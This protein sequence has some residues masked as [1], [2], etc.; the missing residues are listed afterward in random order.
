MDMMETQRFFPNVLIVD[1]KEKD[2]DASMVGGPSIMPPDREIKFVVNMDD[3]LGKIEY[4]NSKILQFSNEVAQNNQSLSELI[5]HMNIVN[6]NLEDIS[7]FMKKSFNRSI[8]AQVNAFARKTAKIEKEVIQAIKQE[9]ER[10][11]R[12][13]SGKILQDVTEDKA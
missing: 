8:N 11:H 13:M 10:S 3:V 6:H 1:A 7:T 12:E 4:L 5:R 9:I 2:T